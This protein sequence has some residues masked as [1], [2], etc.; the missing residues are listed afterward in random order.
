MD[1]RMILQVYVVCTL[2]QK[3]GHVMLI[4]GFF[5][6]FREIPGGLSSVVEAITGH[7]Q[8]SFL[9]V[10]TVVTSTF[11]EYTARFPSTST[12][13]PKLFGS[14]RTTTF[15]LH[16]QQTIATMWSNRLNQTELN[17]MQNKSL[18]QM[19]SI[20]K[21]ILYIEFIQILRTYSFYS[22]KFTFYDQYEVFS[23]L[24]SS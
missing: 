12:G 14:S 17:K 4:I 3:Y 13:S 8:E 23:S 24:H 10:Q 6:L 5:Y 19:I 22:I 7:K 2:I 1:K 15:F 11:P 21:A 20:T 9:L 16:G 18:K